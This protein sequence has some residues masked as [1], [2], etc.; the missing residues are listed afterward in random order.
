MR[1]P[2]GERDEREQREERKDSTIIES[3]TIAA[4]V[5]TAYEGRTGT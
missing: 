2:R 3:H 4:S 1:V 5:V